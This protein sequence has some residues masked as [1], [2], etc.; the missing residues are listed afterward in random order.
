MRVDR[1]RHPHP[2]H[3]RRRGDVAKETVLQVERRARLEV[4]RA[5][6]AGH[7]SEGIRDARAVRDARRALGVP[8]LYVLSLPSVRC[9]GRLRGV[10]RRRSSPRGMACGS[11]PQSRACAKFVT[12]ERQHARADWQSIH[13]AVAIFFF[14]LL[15]SLRLGLSWCNIPR[16]VHSQFRLQQVLIGGHSCTLYRVGLSTA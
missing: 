10:Q 3:S 11:R 9:H 6:D 8:T 13:T 14:S 7:G 1:R 15:Y 2:T 12:G 16:S 4:G 5:D